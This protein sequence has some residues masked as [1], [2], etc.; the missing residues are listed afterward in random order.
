M[1]TSTKSRW[2][3]KNEKAEGMKKVRKLNKRLKEGKW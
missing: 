2:K 1:K 3:E